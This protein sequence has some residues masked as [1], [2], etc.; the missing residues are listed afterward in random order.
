MRVL[1][2]RHFDETCYC[3]WLVEGKPERA[4]FL[5]ADLTHIS[6]ITRLQARP[7]A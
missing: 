7:Q 2:V 3:E 6:F 1:A 4:F 5:L